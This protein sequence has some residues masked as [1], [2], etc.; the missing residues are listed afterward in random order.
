M[1]IS[2]QGLQMEILLKIKQSGNSQFDFL[3]F[4]NELYPYYKHLI[5]II[6]TGRYKPVLDAQDSQIGK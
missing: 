4:D 1:F 5:T 3:S 6:K 2:S